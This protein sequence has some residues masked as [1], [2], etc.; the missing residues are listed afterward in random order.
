MDE[1]MLGA[2]VEGEDHAVGSGFLVDR[3]AGHLLVDVALVDDDRVAHPPGRGVDGAD[4]VAA[5]KG[6]GHMLR[7]VQDRAIRR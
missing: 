2:A 4:L 7:D 6:T 5:R 3:P 1:R